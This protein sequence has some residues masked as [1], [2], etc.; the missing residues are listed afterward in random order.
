MGLIY[1]LLVGRV[2]HDKL[3]QFAAFLLGG[4][5]LPMDTHDA[6]ISTNI[7]RRITICVP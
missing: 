6:K 7:F 2:E 5:I 3:L 1:P 4:P